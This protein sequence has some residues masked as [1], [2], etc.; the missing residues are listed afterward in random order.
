MRSENGDCKIGR[1]KQKPEN[2]MKQ[3]QTGASDVLSLVHSFRT[4]NMMLLERMLHKRYWQCR[5]KGEWFAMSDEE[6]AGFANACEKLE[7]IIGIL[8]GENYHIRKIYGDK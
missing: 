8:D 5:K 3:L 2:R 4:S 6:I 7:R 1:T